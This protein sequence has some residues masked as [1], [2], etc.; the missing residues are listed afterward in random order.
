MYKRKEFRA[1]LVARELAR[2][3]IDSYLFAMELFFEKHQTLTAEDGIAWKK[4]LLESGKSPKTVN[5]R[6]C[7]FNNYCKMEG[8]PISIR[9]MKIQQSTS[10]SN[11]ISRQEYERL[12]AG[13]L[14]DKQVRWYWN[15]KLLAATGARVSEYIR[16]TK[17]DF[18]RG[19]AEQWTKGK[20]RRIYIP[21]SFREEAAEY[22]NNLKPGDF[23]ARGRHGPIT[24][25]GIA[26]QLRNF[27]KKY[28]I[29]PAVMHPHSF[30]HMF[31]IEFLK[32]NN[33]LSL[34]ADVMGHSSVSTT[35][36]YT[37]LT[38]EQQIAEINKAVSW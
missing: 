10:V 32:Q 5:L 12:L 13:L 35:A 34:L 21:S 9:R 38:Q 19:Y 20:I 1:W 15:I 14:G 23:L 7:A 28:G 6:L 3:T 2:N 27:S 30:R 16:L 22:Y 26:Q 24:T 4:E 31:A 29:D 17:S 36:I 11:V 37:R 33:N 18:D 8:V 25:R